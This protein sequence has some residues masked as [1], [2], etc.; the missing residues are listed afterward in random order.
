MVYEHLLPRR[1]F[2]TTWRQKVSRYGVLW[3]LVVTLRLVPGSLFRRLRAGAIDS[4]RELVR[5]YSLLRA[6][7]RPL[8]CGR[9]F[10]IPPRSYYPFYKSVAL[11]DPRVLAGAAA[12]GFCALVFVVLW[13]RHRRVPSVWSG[14]SS[15]LLPVLNSRWLTRWPTLPLY[16]LRGFLLGGGSGAFLESGMGRRRGLLKSRRFRCRE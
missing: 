11:L 3:P 5:S 16:S 12:L 6:V 9:Q 7:G 4:E 15:T 2:G 14:S 13:N 10:G 1:P 8:L